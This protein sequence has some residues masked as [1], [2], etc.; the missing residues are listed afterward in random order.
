[1][2]VRVGDE[3]A[4]MPTAN[5]RPHQILAIGKVCY[6][7]PVFLQISDGRMFANYDGRGV[8]NPCWVAELTEKHRKALIK[9]NPSA[10]VAIAAKI[11]L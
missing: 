1:M 6:I 10:A 2:T 4:I 7:G 5:A 11:V 3:I 8:D 9:A